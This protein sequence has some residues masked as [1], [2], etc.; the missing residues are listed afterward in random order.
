MSVTK[1]ADLTLSLLKV[2]EGFTAIVDQPTDTDII[3]IQQL[4]LPVLMKTKYDEITLTRNLSGVILPTNR[5][6]HIYSKG[7][8]SISLVITLHNDTIDRDT[9]RREV[10]QS[11]GK[12]ED[13]LNDLALYERVYTV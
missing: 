1:P 9:T 5:Y 11:K 8:Y 3:N 2:T 12:H 4:I 10:H 7:G 13:K 6:K